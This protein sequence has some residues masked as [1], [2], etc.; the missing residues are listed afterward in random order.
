MTRIPERFRATLRESATL[1]F[2]AA[3]TLLAGLLAWANWSD[4][5]TVRM[6][7]ESAAEN[8]VVAVYFDD[9][10]GYR[11]AAS[12]SR[13]LRRG[14]H[15]YELAL[16]VSR[17]NSFRIDPSTHDQTTR[18]SGV[19][20]LSRGKPVKR[21]GAGALLPANE[22]AYSQAEDGGRTLSF[23]VQKGGSDP[24]FMVASSAVEAP[25]PEA[26]WIAAIV[27]AA[28]LAAM[29][30]TIAARTAAAAARSGEAP[31]FRFGIMVALVLAMALVA[32]TTHSVSPDEFSHLAAARYYLDHWLPP[33]IGAAETLGS[34]SVYGASYLNEL[35]IVY[36]VA[37]KFVVATAFIGVEET[38]RFRLFNV[39]LL[40][41]CMLPATRRRLAA[42]LLLPLLCTAQAWYV[43]AYFNADAF[44]LATMFLLAAAVLAHF[45][46]A[47]SPAATPGI[48]WSRALVIGVLLGLAFLCK[49]TFYPFIV[50]V[51]S[52]ALWRSGFR[53]WMGYAAGFVGLALLVAWNF[54]GAASPAVASL[55]P[56]WQRGILAFAGL[57]SMVA[58]AWIVLAADRHAVPAPHVLIRA[59]LVAAAVVGA[60]LLMDVA[61]NGAPWEQSRTLFELTE[62]LARPDFRPSAMGTAQSY[63]GL[64]LAWKGVTL[65]EMLFSKF[66]WVSNVTA[67]FFGVYGYMNIIGPAW[68]YETQ[69]VLGMVFVATLAAAGFARAPARGTAVLG[70]ACIAFAIAITMIYSWVR[71]LQA[72]GRYLLVVLPILGVMAADAARAASAEAFDLRLARA[73]AAILWVLAAMSFA[74]I[75]LPGMVRA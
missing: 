64:A 15:R 39:F 65:H 6:E 74:F 35:D 63:F 46:R 4:R 59:A 56:A 36:L 72:Q 5:L 18:I 50:F 34:Y 45:E 12:V 22:I 29:A 58:G 53:R 31:L 41:L 73:V 47:E 11:E 3:A 60:R 25:P 10:K 16:P 71:D 7:I 1:R 38:V 28:L 44:A 27:F 54:S 51:V 40:G 32:T 62:R 33:R 21:F 70:L 19:E 30:I 43:F 9:G 8:G 68:L 67:S 69:R 37:A 48:D 17:I 57:G 75:G 49:K 13:P 26:S 55:L 23:T 14:Y 20:A 42:W 24:Y 52:Y 2:A 66:D 61:V